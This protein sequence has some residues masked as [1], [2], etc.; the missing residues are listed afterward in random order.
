M[1]SIEVIVPRAWLTV[2]ANMIE[3]MIEQAKNTSAHANTR[4]S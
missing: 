1:V 2:E 4:R 3:V